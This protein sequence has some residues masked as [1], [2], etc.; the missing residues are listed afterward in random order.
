M[1]V[2]LSFVE[3]ESRQM[4]VRRD[5]LITPKGERLAAMVVRELDDLL[6]PLLSDGIQKASSTPCWSQRR[7]AA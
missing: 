5:D 3:R 2:S 7:M 4:W 6:K 1:T